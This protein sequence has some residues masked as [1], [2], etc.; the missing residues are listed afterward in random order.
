MEVATAGSSTGVSMLYDFDD[1]DVID[2]GGDETFLQSGDSGGPSFASWNGELVL[3]GIHWFNGKPSAGP[4]YSGD[5]FVPSYVGD[6]NSK[7]SGETLTVVPEPS[8]SIFY[9]NSAWDD[10]GGAANAA[11]DNAIA[12]DKV[13]LRPGIKATFANYTS[14]DKGINGLMIDLYGLPGT[15]TLNDF[16]FRKG[17]D[18]KPYGNDL[19]DPADDWP[20]APDPIAVAVRPVGPGRRGPGDADLGRR[21]HPQLLAPGD[22]DGHRP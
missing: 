21:C 20:W 12:P 3:L 11:D 18:N 5:T 1:N 19:N 10:R 2:V 17:N 16:L 13:A 22:R 14:Y 4:W 8:V 15:P 9:N 6:I 7:M